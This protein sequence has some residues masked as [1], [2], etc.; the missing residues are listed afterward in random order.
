[1][2]QSK[3]LFTNNQWKP[4]KGAPFVS[5]NPS[6]GEIL[7]EGNACCIEEVNESLENSKDAF[8]S[9]SER[10]LEERYLY[11]IKFSEILKSNQTE[12]SLMISKETGKPLWDSKG[13]VQSMINKIPLSLEAYQQRCPNRLHQ[14][15]AIHS[16]TRHRPHGIVAVFGPYNFPGHLS[17]GHIIPALLAGNCVVFKPSELTPLVTETLAGY[18]QQVNLPNGVLNITQGGR[19]TG[20]A[21][22]NHRLIDGIFFTGSSKTGL[23][24]HQQFASSPE[25]I[26]ALELGGNN[27]LVIS[28]ISD[29]QAALYL[30]I[31]SAFLSSGQRCTCARRLI[32]ID[33]QKNR[34]FV[35]QLVELIPRLVIGPYDHRPE[36]YL[37]P[38]ISHEQVQNLLRTQDWLTTQ[39]GTSLVKMNSLLPNTGFISPGLMDIT[40]IKESID[41]E[42]FGPFLQLIWVS[43]LDEAIKEANR[44]Q[45]GLTS[46]IVTDREEEWERFYRES[47]AGVINWNVQLTGASSAAPFGGIKKSGNNR[48]SAFYAADYCSYPV[49]SL[50]SSQ[51]KHPETLSPGIPLDGK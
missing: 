23:L 12:L 28:Q 21:L 17:H 19:E 39:G 2:I 11:L 5:V 29:M 24:I 26:L 41:E 15:T 38:V 45:Y 30:T 25:K 22:L 35:N 13:E 40:A 14:K 33:S 47:Q 18:W 7:W 50:E 10:L 16:V 8:K 51:L 42:I 44:T 3:S 20:Q 1:M 32:V 31:Q 48:P 43:N 9:W 4:A 6:N 27:P 49:A 36:P 46:G 34:E 37:G